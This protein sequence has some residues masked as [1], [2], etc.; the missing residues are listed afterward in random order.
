MRKLVSLLAAAAFVFAFG[1]GGAATGPATAAEPDLSAACDQ[2]DSVGGGQPGVSLSRDDYPVDIL[3]LCHQVL[4]YRYHI[5]GQLSDCRVATLPLLQLDH[6][7]VTIV[8]LGA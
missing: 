1:F 5:S 8:L 7:E 2:A 6:D 3:T 4:P